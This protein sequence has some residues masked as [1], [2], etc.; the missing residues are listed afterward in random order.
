VKKLAH[1]PAGATFDKKENEWSFGKRLRG[2]RVGVWQF[3]KAPSGY[4]IAEY[5]FTDGPDERA[6]S[7]KSFHPNGDLAEEGTYDSGGRVTSQTWRRTKGQTSEAPPYWAEF[8]P[9]AWAMTRG[10]EN[11]TSGG[12][13]R[14]FDKQGAEL[15]ERGK[16]LRA[17]KAAKLAARSQCLGFLKRPAHESAANAVDRYQ[18][19]FDR[20][21]ELQG[22]SPKDES[23][24]DDRLVFHR[25]PVTPAVIARAEKRYGVTL[26]PS[27]VEFVTKRGLFSLGN[28]HESR[29]NAPDSMQSVYSWHVENGCDHE[30]MVRQF[31]LRAP[32]IRLWKQ[33][34]GFSDGDRE[35]QLVALYCFRFDSQNPKT[36][37][38]SVWAF[39]S[40]DPRDFAK[41]TGKVCA[42]RGF[43]EHIARIVDE[44]I[45]EMID[46]G[47]PKANLKKR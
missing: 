26:P 10:A 13:L 46:E 32:G 35:L 2:K 22:V 11:P 40:E 6:K 38:A 47:F 21:V 16:P 15:D 23:V 24:K 29:L 30:T 45:S 44:K 4:L 19:F 37:E 8:A 43:D 12:A 17:A 31:K 42:T 14:Y 28:S 34:L 39:D 1:I 33:S 7:W 3:W 5:V 25:K 41:P 36:K 18:R 20:F 9:G 27:Y